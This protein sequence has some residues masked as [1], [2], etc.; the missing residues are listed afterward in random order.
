MQAYSE[1]KLPFDGINII[2]PTAA[3]DCGHR[4]EWA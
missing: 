3:D 1:Q 2:L 4:L